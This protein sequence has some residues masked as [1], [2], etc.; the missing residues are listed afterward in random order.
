MLDKLVRI[1]SDHLGRGDRWHARGIP[2]LLLTATHTA[3]S[4]G[5]L[6]AA[7]EGVW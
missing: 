6:A 3:Y 5:V 1:A 2:R 4:V 7:C